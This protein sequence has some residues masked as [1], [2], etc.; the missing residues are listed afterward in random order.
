MRIYAVCLWCGLTT[1]AT[2]SPRTRNNARRTV[3]PAPMRAVN[4]PSG[5]RSSG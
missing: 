2:R 4:E 1:A 5:P 3:C